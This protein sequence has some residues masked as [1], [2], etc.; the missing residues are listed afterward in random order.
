MVK[1]ER[2]PAIEGWNRME[3]PLGYILGCSAD[4]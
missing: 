4:D 3:L 2:V 1:E